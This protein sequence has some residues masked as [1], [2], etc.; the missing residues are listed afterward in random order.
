VPPVLDPDVFAKGGDLDLDPIEDDH[1]DAER[2][3]DRDRLLEERL[4]LLGPCR[5]GDV[6]VV[7]RP[8]EQAV[9]H[10]SAGEQRLMP[11]R[12]ECPCYRVRPIPHG[13]T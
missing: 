1:D 2:R 12:S 8:A 13:P 4:D 7:D 11:C 5:G 6:V 10:A 9:P 3:A